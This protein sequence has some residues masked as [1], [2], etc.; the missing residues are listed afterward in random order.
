VAIYPANQHVGELLQQGGRVMC[1]FALAFGLAVLVS[2]ELPMDVVETQMRQFHIP[3]QIAPADRA[4][5]EKV[6]LFVSADRGKTWKRVSD[7]KPTDFSFTFK[8]GR[9]FH[10]YWFALQVHSKDGSIDPAETKSLRPELKV[11]VNPFKKAFKVQTTQ[12]K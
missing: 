9:D 5:I 8:D 4:M 12:S 10:N 7:C 11:Y 1:G 3:L 2:P 6:R